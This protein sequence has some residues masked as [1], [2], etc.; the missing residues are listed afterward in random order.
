MHTL[1]LTVLITLSYFVGAFFEWLAGD[2]EG[3]GMRVFHILAGIA[4]ISC[5]LTFVSRGW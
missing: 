5:L 3:R 4:L 2:L 1:H